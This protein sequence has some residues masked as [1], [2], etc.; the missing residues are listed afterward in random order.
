[1][2]FPSP[3]ASTTLVSVFVLL[4]SFAPTLHAQEPRIV[5]RDVTVVDVEAGRHVEHQ[6]VYVRD[7]RIEAVVQAGVRANEGDIAV[8]GSD[9]FVIPGLWNFHTH[10]TMEE[11]EGYAERS[12]DAFVPHGVLT[13]V[14]M[15]GDLE[16]IRAWRAEIAAGTRR[17][18]RILAAGPFID[19]AKALDGSE[20]MRQWRRASTVE[21]GSA[22]EIQTAV[23]E[24]A[25]LVDVFK[26]HSR[27]PK[28]AFLAL[29]REARQIGKP[30]VVHLPVGITPLETVRAGASTIE[31]TISFL[32]DA[33][34]RD[35]P[36]AFR[37]DVERAV[38][39]LR[40]PA[41]RALFRELAAAGTCVTPTQLAVERL[42]RAQGDP[43]FSGLIDD[44][45]RIVLTLHAEGVRLLAG[46]DAA[47]EQ[48][49]LSQAEDLLLE[50][51]HLARIGVPARDVLRAATLYP[52]ACLG[53]DDAGRIRAGALADLVL[54][55][56]SPLLDVSNVR[57]IHS[58]IVR[59]RYV[60]ADELGAGPSVR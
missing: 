41:G 37:A 49:G 3:R 17:G 27:L 1:M 18:P 13:A 19:G 32:G 57:S 35:D 2:S 8:D 4:A 21:I 12:L 55:K 60:T 23:R 7:E 39:R 52:A 56:E 10:L 31:H 42:A 40:G 26:V 14:D 16:R 50:L 29:A 58:V 51:E 30:L 46:T 15:G 38:E 33:L 54:L 9:L 59:G 20:R 6:D 44:L 43:F 24:L 25:P 36:D 48:L 5:I 28:D 11:S 34:Y 53:Y 47:S 22:D 45:D